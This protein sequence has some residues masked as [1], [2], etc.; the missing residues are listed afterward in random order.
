MGLLRD[1]SDSISDEAVQYWTDGYK[2]S[3]QYV[4]THG[5]NVLQTLLVPGPLLESIKD[6]DRYKENA[7]RIGE[8]EAHNAIKTDRL[9]KSVTV[10]EITASKYWSEISE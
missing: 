2:L 9:N 8:Q 5:A 4:P 10:R 7:M 6:H 1:L 3:P